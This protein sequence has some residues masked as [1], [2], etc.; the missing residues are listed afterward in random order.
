[1]S[2][3]YVT[4]SEANAYF[5]ERLHSGLW[6]ET[7]LTDRTAALLD[8]TRRIDRLNFNGDKADSA[9]E[10]QFP[11]GADTAIP[12]DIKIACMESAFAL[13]QGVDPEREA[14][15]L[16]VVS[17][18]YSSV[19]TTYDRSLEQQ[20]FAAGIPSMIA[21]RYLLPFLREQRTIR[22]SRV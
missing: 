4:I 22:V 17:Q 16:S 5:A 10:L 1:M 13:L 11:R 15:N 7:N 14:T 3:A 12:N 19:R 2:T 6:G 21:W 8:A 18:G 9:Q 20:H